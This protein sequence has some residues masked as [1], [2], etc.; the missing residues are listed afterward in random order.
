MPVGR[1]RHLFPVLATS[2]AILA[3]AAPASATTFTVTQ[4]A[5][6]TGGTCTAVSCSLRQAIAAAGNGDTVALPASATAYTLT[7]GQL[8][9][10]AGITIQGAGAGATTVRAQ[11]S[12]RVMLVNGNPTAVRLVNLTVTG[13]ST[14]KVGGGGIAA[15][16]PGPLVLQ[17]VSVTGNH[18]APSGAGFNEGGGGV[19]SSAPLTLR[20]STI[21]G[22]SVVVAA[23]HGDSGGGGILATSGDLTITDSTVSANTATVTPDPSAGVDNNGGGG[24]YMDGSDLTITRSVFQGNTTTITGNI[25]ATPADGG[26][27]IYQFGTNMLLQDSTVSGNVAHG[28]GVDKGGGGGVFDDGDTSRYLDS[29]IANNSTDEPATIL[30]AP[31][32][33]SDGGG[34]VL[35]D[36]VKG[37][38]VMANMTISGNSATAA[39]GGGLNSVLTTSVDITD[40]LLVGNTAHIGG[41]N[42]AGPMRSDGYNLADDTAAN[43]CQLTATGDLL[44]SSPKLGALGNNGGPTPTEALLSGSPAIDAGNPTGCTDLLGDPVLTDQ[45]G[46]A[47]PQ[48]PGGRCDIGAYERAPAMVLS[49]AATPAMLSARLSAVVSNPDARN[50]SVSFQYG[51]TRSYGKSTPAQIVPAFSIGSS[52]SALVAALA[53]GSYHF[54][55]VLSNATGTTNGSDVTF[56]IQRVNPSRFTA[57]VKPK[58]DLHPLAHF[59]I[60]GH[61]TPPVGVGSAIACKGTVSVR[62]TLLGKSIAK[63]HA[64]LGGS[65]GYRIA[66]KLG[67]RGLSGHFTAHLSVRFGGNSALTARSAPGLSVKFG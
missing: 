29:T 9:V 2:L 24:V 8:V 64:K 4:T 62:A 40:S 54:R 32:P 27:G 59:T 39:A 22:N 25:V 51:P 26:G 46:V 3:T 53:P 35:F 33:G 66:L 23:S 28:P 14:T 49:S 16:G 17:G 30:G 41:G 10:G 65:C 1:T 31:D 56:R 15:A 57:R 48:P 61:L 58:S 6:S 21:T 63:A 55:A 42:C 34:G 37:G 45:R 50:G 20:H 12:D 44:S 67:H 11:D 43:S 19:F 5:D 18:D 13:G 52:F 38:V 7:H 60:S 47:R 36:T